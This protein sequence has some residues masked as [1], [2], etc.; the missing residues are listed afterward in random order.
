MRALTDK[1]EKFVQGLLKGL[2]QRQAY[3]ESYNASNMKDNT[4]DRK[5]YGIMQK[6]Y[7]RARYNE[8]HDKVV[9]RAE[10]K[11]IFTVESILKELSDLIA[12]NKEEDDRVA[13]DGIKT[14]MKHL[15]MLTDKV[16]HSGEIK[17]P[18]ITIV[19]K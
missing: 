17:L 11:A 14:A 9:Q 8:L 6:D 10:E 7:V 16:E 3:K 2:S 13:L 12:R 18:N 5:A 19:S 1:Q 4:I 15:G